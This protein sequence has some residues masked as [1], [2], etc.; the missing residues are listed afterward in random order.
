MQHGGLT[1]N[2]VPA[3]YNTVSSLP[4]SQN[5]TKTIDYIVYQ[6][7]MIAIHFL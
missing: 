4:L 5:P 1:G 6:L 7:F 3:L 2:K